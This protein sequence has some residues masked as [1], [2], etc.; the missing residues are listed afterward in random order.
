MEQLRTVRTGLGEITY[1]LMKKNV[2]NMNLRVDADGEI[3]LSIPL[4][5]AAQT[6]DDFIRRKSQWIL[7][8]RTR[9]A[10]RPMVELLPEL[11]REMCYDLLVES[12]ERVYPLVANYGVKKPAV[13]I[14]KMRSQWGNCH[15]MQG[16]ITLNTM[17]HRC[18]RHLRDYVALHELIHFLYHD[19]GSGFH[20]AMDSL[21]PN[22]RE[23]RRE[24][25][26]YAV[27]VLE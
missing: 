24:L 15:W 20:A 6:A 3:I 11:N 19:H 8:H 25:K 21:M 14:R 4:H 26:D 12:V 18:P 27:A 7:E 9:R 1:T 2:K 16:Y 23:Y 22:W 10:E 13:K 5:C 17:L